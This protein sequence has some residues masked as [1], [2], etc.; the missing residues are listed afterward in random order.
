MRAIN[1]QIW[2]Q[3]ALHKKRIFRLMT[4]ILLE[5][6]IILVLAWALITQPLFSP[7]QAHKN[8]PAVDPAKLEAH[9][10]TIVE[11]LSPRDGEH[12]QNLDRVA[13]YIRLKFEN[14][15][16]RVAEQPYKTMGHSYRNI[17]ASFG[18]E[19]GQRIIVGAHYDAA[20]P[21][22]GSDDNAS[23]VA[24]LLELSW[25]LGNAP[26]RVRVD[27]AA[28]SLEEYF[29]TS[30]MGSA[31]HAQSLKRQNTSVRLMISLEMIGCFTDAPN[32]QSM[33]V[34]FIKPFYPTAGNFIAV[35]GS[36]G[37][38]RGVREVK[39]AMRAA[40]D[41][42]VCSLNAPR[43]IP[44][45]DWSDH[46][47]FWDTGYDAVMVTDT[48]FLRN[49]RYHTIYD[50]PDTLDYKRMAKVVQGVYAAVLDLAQ[51]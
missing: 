37:Q 38:W 28:Y 24:G 15:N 3:E 47:N 22:P 51:K 13:E 7:S 44:G 48:A 50:T 5:V 20:G 9:V 17:L 18:P 27:L 46:L 26:P 42:P 40:S 14:A 43:S 16:G 8:L 4:R 35:V 45:V 12:P 32:S 36:L 23:G 33:P 10:R 6:L 30:Y 34:S 41:L 19:T 39:G 25:L 11:Q 1:D 29:G 21:K 49:K 31:V 2:Q